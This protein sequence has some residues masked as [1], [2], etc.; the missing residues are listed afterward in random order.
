MDG[1]E[2]LK[3]RRNIETALEDKDGRGKIKT[4]GKLIDF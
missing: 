4:A 1:I 2:S 3:S